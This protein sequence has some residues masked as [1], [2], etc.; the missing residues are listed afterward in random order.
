MCVACMHSTGQRGSSHCN[1]RS[2][3]TSALYASCWAKRRQRPWRTQ[4][5]SIVKGGHGCWPGAQQ[6]STSQRPSFAGCPLYC[7]SRTGSA[8]AKR[9]LSLASLVK[10][11]GSQP[12]PAQVLSGSSACGL[13]TPR[14]VA[15]CCCLPAIPAG[16]RGGGLP[17]SCGRYLA[18]ACAPQGLWGEDLCAGRRPSSRAVH[19]SRLPSGCLQ[20]QSGKIRSR[21]F[22]GAA[23]QQGRC[24]GDSW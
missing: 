6:H 17:R 16:S 8:I 18:R 12:L 23:V 13:S 11:Y 14:A 9:V 4:R 5:G 19:G 7:G 10:H 20:R 2:F 3:L 24:A 1:S 21:E 22:N 15:A